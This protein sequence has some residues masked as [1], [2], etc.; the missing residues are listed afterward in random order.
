MHWC[1]KVKNMVYQLTPI[2]ASYSLIFPI[3]TPH[4][5]KNQVES[6][7]I[8]FYVE[9]KQRYKVRENQKKQRNFGKIALEIFF[10]KKNLFSLYSLSY[11]K[12]YLLFFYLVNILWVRSWDWF[13]SL[14]TKP[15]PPFYFVI[16]FPYTKIIII[17]FLYFVVQIVALFHYVVVYF[18]L[19]LTPF[20]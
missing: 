4:F 7:E 20:F 10:K 12:K 14:I 5:W 13:S 2:L 16:I 17:S 6:L 18:V 1:T 3:N 19:L 8:E 11:T 15:I 9:K